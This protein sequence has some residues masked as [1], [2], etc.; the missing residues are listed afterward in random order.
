MPLWPEPAVIDS[1]DAQN[2]PADLCAELGPFAMDVA[3]NPRSKIQAIKHVMLENGEDGLTI[4]WRGSVYCNGPYSDPLPWC[5]RLARHDG[6]W[7]ALWK[8]DPTTR[9]FAVLMGACDAWAPFRKRLRFDREGNSGVANFPSV[10]VWGGGWTP[11]DAVT[12]R[13]WR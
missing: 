5:E 3:S 13:L 12:A 1:D 4:E 9:W 8:L 7:C 6:P 11:S 10:L 2:T